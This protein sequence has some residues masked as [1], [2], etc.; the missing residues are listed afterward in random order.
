M[1]QGLVSYG[2]L[3][4]KPLQKPLFMRVLENL[5]LF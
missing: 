2:F 3:Q 1:M 5:F 4:Q